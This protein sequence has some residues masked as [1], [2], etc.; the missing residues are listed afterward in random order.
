MKI[1][2][3]K[4]WW[5]GSILGFTLCWHSVGVCQDR[6]FFQQGRQIVELR[7]L[8]PLV[9][10]SLSLSA[11]LIPGQIQVRVRNQLILV[12]QQP[13]QLP[14]QSLAIRSLI[15]QLQLLHQYQDKYLYQI[16]TATLQDSLQLLRLLQQQPEILQIQP[17]LLPLRQALQADAASEPVSTAELQFDASTF[18]LYRYAALAQLWRK[19]R[20]KGVRIALI[21]NGFTFKHQALQQVKPVF[22]HDVDMNI[23]GAVAE[24]SASHGDKVAALIWGRAILAPQVEAEAP[25]PGQAF[26]L[27]PEAAMI[28]L[29]LTKPWTSQLLQAF[30]LA[31]Q[32]QAD[33]INLSWLLPWLA[34]PLQD[35]LQYLV[36]SANQGKGIVIVA[37]ANPAPGANSGLAAMPEL[38]VVS[39]T[40]HQGQLA[41]AS[42]GES[43][44]IA[45]VSFILS[46]HPQQTTVFAMMAK[47]SASA[48]IVSAVVALLRASVPNLTAPQIE[49]LL[50]RSANVSTEVNSKGDT[51]HYRVLNVN[52]ALRQ[53]F[54]LAKE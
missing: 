44:D 30:I 18:N 26:G 53:L 34:T 48:A 24:Q 11:E 2:V 52:A 40:D 10:H 1:E 35:Y 31:E 6:F 16:S 47:T 50:K 36:Q 5:F 28:A 4:Q 37:A 8:Q 25:Q 51:L 45:A 33:V 39:S 38:L 32:Q 22:S 19:T 14:K 54:E 21:D 23:P 43:V 13:Y 49:L 17:D 27:A 7:L 46:I 41:N 9:E 12:T 42:W 3:V 15:Q 20:G 29:K